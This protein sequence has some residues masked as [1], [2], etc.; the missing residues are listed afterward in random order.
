[1]NGRDFHWPAA[2]GSLKLRITA[3][4][5]AALV[6]GIG[7]IT[8]LLVTRAERD[9]LEAQ[10]VRE[11]SETVRTAGLLSRQVVELQRALASV[12]PQFSDIAADDRGALLRLIESQRVLRQ[13][14][15]NVFATSADGQVLV[16]ADSRQVTLPASLNIG[17]RDYFQK[18]VRE[19]RAIISDATPSRV[20][21]QPLIIL[22]QPVRDAAGTLMIFS[23]SLRLNTRDLLDGLVEDNDDATAAL[24]V[25]TDQTGRVLAHPNRDRLLTLLSSEPRLAQAFAAWQAIGAPV[26]PTGVRLPQHGAL[27]SAAGVPG[28]DWMVWR[29]RAEADVLAPLRAARADAIL[30]AVVLLALL[31]PLLFVMLWRALRPLTLLEHRAQHL[32]DGSL[33]P[34]AGWPGGRGEIGRLSAVLRRVGLERLTLEAQNAKTM[35]KLNS[36][37]SAAPVG[38]AFTRDDRFELVSAELCR[39]VVATPQD[40]LGQPLR[41]LF[42]SGDDHGAFLARERSDFRALQPYTGEWQLLRHDGSKFWAGLRTK[43]VDLADRTL[44]TIWIVSDIEDQRAVR[45][46]LEWSAT[47]DALTGLVNREAFEQQARR[48]VE[49]QPDSRPAALVFLDLDRF[50]PVNDTAG[51]LVGDLMLLTVATA[52][53]AHVRTGDLVARMGGDEFAL[54]LENCPPDAA[55]TIA[56]EVRRA[57]T[58]VVVPSTHG[59][60]SVGASIGVAALQA[61]IATV[62]DWLQAADAACYAAKSAG[63]DTVRA[64]PMGAGSAG[65]A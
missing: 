37:M 19:N 60:L 56:D 1:M 27:V 10:L 17:D 46:Q 16:A 55:M 30:G 53:A 35:R 40:L 50:K 22:T 2:L 54:L 38:I 25:V 29:V 14:F 11:S 64:A 33:Q 62:N 36:V 47:H 12:A 5:I 26:E 28:P 63:R 61:N 39:L 15:T 6:V 49:T 59:P 41:T 18:T 8:A 44:G 9:T 51:H 20:N 43:P 24:V 3:G 13:L 65:G 52:I 7:L 34:D 48:L 42:A 45:Q 23:G 21:G 31:S 57:V 4:G 58:E 32:F